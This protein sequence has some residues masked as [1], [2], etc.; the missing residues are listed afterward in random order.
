MANLASLQAI[1]QNFVSST[2]DIQGAVIVT[3]DGLPLASTLPSGMDEERT[4]AMSA[5]M[6]S[7]GERIG[8]ELARGT[9]E[10]IFV[11]GDKGYGVLTS[12]GAD[13]VL[14]T[15]ASAEVKQG[16][17]FLE[18]KRVTESVTIAMR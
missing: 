10:R 7:L 12:C 17:L 9:I 3:P 15:L 5:A 11:Q 8:K 6:L 2:P 18:I 14:L 1:L 4:S 13:A 16:M